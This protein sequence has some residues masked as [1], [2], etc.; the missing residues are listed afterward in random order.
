MRSFLLALVFLALPVLA[1]AQQAVSG[2]EKVA[3]DQ[4]A[5]DLNTAQSYVYAVYIDSGP[6]TVLS[7]VSCTGTAA[8]FQCQVPFPAATPGQHTLQLTAAN[9]INGQTAESVKS[10]PLP[11]VLIVAPD[12]PTNLRIVSGN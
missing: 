10:A 8:P 3:W 11:F 4:N 12:A 6:R 2:N 7:G 1:S 9:V 5:P